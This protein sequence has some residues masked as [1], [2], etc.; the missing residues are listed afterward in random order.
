VKEASQLA[1][2]KE[3]SQLAA[4]KEASQLPLGALD[5]NIVQTASYDAV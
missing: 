2:V 4:V 5:A 1:A 3:A